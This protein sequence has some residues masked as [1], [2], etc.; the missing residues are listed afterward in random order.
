MDNTTVYFVRHGEYE[1]PG[2]VNPFRM[3]GF[4]LSEKGKQQIISTVKILQDKNITSL[5]SSPILRTKQ[6]AEIIGKELKL[7]PEICEQFNEVDTPFMGYPREEVNK[8]VI[9]FFNPYHIAKGGESMED[10]YNRME[11]GVFK[12]LKK[13]KSKKII[14]ISHGDPITIFVYHK[15]GIPLKEDFWTHFPY[16]PMSGILQTDFKDD[17]LIFLR[18]INY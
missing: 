6:S 5:Y 16:I 4:P 8:K 3:N 13:N 9:F 15:K 10:V 12:I 11:K 17:E 18:Q 2:N 14:I 7:V 1:N